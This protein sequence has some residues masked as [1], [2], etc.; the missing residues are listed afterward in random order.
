MA[1]GTAR[2]VC[3]SRR[4]KPQRQQ[5]TRRWTKTMTAMT[6]SLSV[7]RV[8]LTLQPWKRAPLPPEGALGGP[9]TANGSIVGGG[10]ITT[11][12]ADA[13]GT[14]VTTLPLGVGASA[15]A[16]RSAT[17]LSAH[18]LMTPRQRHLVAEL[19]LPCLQQSQQ[20][21]QQQL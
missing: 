15:T 13:T 11:P 6:A 20:S 16:I 14:P 18:T 17:R 21:Q 8:P 7:L 1:A 4:L 5:S 2:T 3:D 9:R 19:P 10:S 12:A